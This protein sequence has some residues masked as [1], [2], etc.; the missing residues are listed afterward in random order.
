MSKET[1][2]ELDKIPYIVM[3]SKDVLKIGKI[4]NDLINKDDFTMVFTIHL[5]DETIE[6]DWIKKGCDDSCGTDCF[7]CLEWDFEREIKND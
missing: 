7:D 6:V 4:A 2:I 1:I 3:D 5:G